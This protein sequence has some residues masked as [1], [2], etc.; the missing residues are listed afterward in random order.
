[1]VDIVIMSPNERKR[2][3]F[4]GIMSFLERGGTSY[5]RIMSVCER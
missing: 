5:H 4:C 3:S 1:M 2:P